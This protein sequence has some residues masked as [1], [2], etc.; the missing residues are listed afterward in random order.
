M[1][2]VRGMVKVGDDECVEVVYGYRNEE[3]GD[4]ER[5]ENVFVGGEE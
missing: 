4:G 3:I 2:G 5:M 1:E